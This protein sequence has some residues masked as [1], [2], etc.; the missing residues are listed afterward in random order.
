M[1]TLKSIEGCPFSQI[2]QSQ[3]ENMERAV[4]ADYQSL[5]FMDAS[6]EASTHS[7]LH[8]CLFS[9][10]RFN[11]R[12]VNCFWESHR[13]SYGTSRFLKGTR[14]R[15]KNE[16]SIRWHRHINMGD[17]QWWKQCRMERVAKGNSKTK[18]G[19]G[20]V[21]LTNEMITGWSSWG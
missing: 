17:L 20:N 5:Y 19:N 15:K 12:Y 4:Q 14:K 1:C 2:L 10:V 13:S 16:A 6:Q 8:L 18:T 9:A 11:A 3:G 7:S 21:D